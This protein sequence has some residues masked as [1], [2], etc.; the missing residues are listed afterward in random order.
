ML[1]D[2]LGIPH[3]RH[4]QVHGPSIPII[5]IQV[6]PNLLSYSLPP[7][8]L[9]F[10]IAE[11]EEWLR[12]SFLKASTVQW[13]RLAG[14][15]NWALNVFPLARPGLSNVYDKLR[16]VNTRSGSLWVNTAVRND[17]TW[18]LA[19][20]QSSSGLLLL[21]NVHWDP[22]T[23][24]FTIYC[25]ACPTGM[26]FWY[27][28][29]AIGFYADTPLNANSSLIFF[30]EAL[31]VLSAIADACSRAA[32]PCRIVCFT[33]NSNT[34]DIFS[35]LHALPPYNPI[36]RAAVDL[37]HA[38]HHDLRVLHVPGDLNTVADALSRRE[39]ND[40]INL[41]PDLTISHFEPYHSNN[42]RTFSLTPPRSALGAL[43]K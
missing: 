32:F 24:D 42:D 39:F 40:A 17:L 19:L 25:D 30:F 7:D 16:G 18:T 26:G 41:C 11:L 10:L 29:L 37:L 27:P 35:S 36:L 8:S 1:W 4:K 21:D 34:V 14:W 28:S 12:P 22:S 9:A 43:R 31:C 13:R 33:D 5:G 20:L 6:N 2:D 23:A 38:G 3:K 15:I